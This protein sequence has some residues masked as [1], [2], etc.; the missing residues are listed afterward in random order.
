MNVFKSLLLM[1]IMIAA[2]QS[3]SRAASLSMLSLDES[4]GN[5]SFEIQ[6]QQSY[7]FTTPSF[8][9]SSNSP[10]GVGPVTLEFII[11]PTT[12]KGAQGGNIQIN[13]SDFVSPY[14]QYVYQRGPQSL[15]TL[16]SSS[17]TP[18]S[19]RRFASTTGDSSLMTLEP[20]DRLA[21]LYSHAPWLNFTNTFDAQMGKQILSI[22]PDPNT[23]N[24]FRYA[25]INDPVEGY[26]STIIQSSSGQIS[27]P[28]DEIVIE[29]PY[30]DVTTSTI[31]QIPITADENVTYPVYCTAPWARLIGEPIR[32]GS[33]T[34]EFEILF[35]D[36]NNPDAQFFISPLNL[37]QTLVIND[38]Q[39]SFNLRTAVIEGWCRQLIDEINFTSRNSGS[40]TVGAINGFNSLYSHEPGCSES[41]S[42]YSITDW[43]TVLDSS[44]IHVTYEVE[45][46]ET[47]QSR[48][49]YVIYGD[50]MHSVIQTAEGELDHWLVD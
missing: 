21:S 11:P 8:V 7:S 19:I 47:G 10:S 28:T 29:D 40:Y 6:D 17:S 33:Q 25:H 30:D 31:I 39:I 14:Y 46:N 44:S 36:Y 12:I 20:S 38:Q 5:W 49:G 16:E 1:I 13:A 15:M 22:N 32:T 2:L 18:T 50:S 27:F 26:S 4:G 45:P 35:N 23:S 34:I 9:R 24:T 3:N 37:F 43:I 42:G 48:T 41:M